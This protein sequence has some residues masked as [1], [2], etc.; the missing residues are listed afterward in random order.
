MAVWNKLAPLH[1]LIGLGIALVG[2]V[3]AGATVAAVETF[4]QFVWW[5]VAQA[6]VAAAGIWL[7]VRSPKIAGGLVVILLVALAIRVI[8]FATPH[9]GLT[10]DA[11][12]YVWDGRIQW[13]G[14]NPYAHVPADPQ[15]AHLRDGDVYPNINQK[16]RA[17]TI[18]PPFAEML[19]LV[20]NAISDSVLGPK[21]VMAVSDIAIIGGLLLLLPLAGLPRDRVIIYAW[22]PLPI[23]EFVSQA[24]IDSAATALLLLALL[25][26]WQRR[27]GVAG[28][29]LALAVMTKYFPLAMIPA[30]WR[31][32]DWR[33]PA[34]FVG[35]SIALA[36]PYWLA[37]QPD[38]TGYLGKHLDN[39]GYASGWGFHGIWMLRD[40]QLADPPG[41]GWVAA[42]LVVLA[43]L[44][45]WAFWMRGRDELVAW[46]MVL[47]AAAFVWL[48]SPHYPWY[49]G[50]I[51][52]LLCL[53][54]SPAILLMTLAAPILYYPRPPGGATWTHL[55]AIVYYLPAVLLLLEVW[56]LHRRTGRETLINRQNP[57][58]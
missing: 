40:F 16:E 4:N 42:S 57:A 37:G 2:L 23:W 15:L 10:T 58:H 35:V 36:L 53:R 26:V 54:L 9:D 20:S 55:Y 33:M 1:V 11:Y 28:G 5:S 22:H 39:E 52:P 45:A 41:W 51:I 50:W 14:W 43:M 7:I 38:L 29:V 56:L 48:T 19:F 31:R 46:H 8:G 25:A 6:V 27:Q 3:G 30:I 17:V 13:D 24:H 49:F 34:V 21:I 47:I 18:Y 44:A 12:R 32:W